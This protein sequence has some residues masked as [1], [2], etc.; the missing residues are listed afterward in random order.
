MPHHRKTDHRNNYQDNLKDPQRV[1]LNFV[2][3]HPGTA[4]AQGE[5]KAGDRQ[6]SG[7]RAILAVTEGPLSLA[8]IGSRG[9]PRI[10]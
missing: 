8:E 4:G 3:H 7:D 9:L 5:G 10:Q 6:K 2:D 1:G